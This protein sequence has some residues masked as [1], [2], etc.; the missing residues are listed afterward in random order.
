MQGPCKGCGSRTAI[1]LTEYGSLVCTACGVENLSYIN[2]MSSAYSPYCVPLHAPVSYTRLKR[3]QKYLQ[4]ASMQQST[5]S[6][7]EATWRYLLAGR[8]YRGPGAIV[9]RLKGAPRTLKK[10]CYDSLPL[11]TKVCCP[12]V[13]VPTLSEHE[14]KRAVLHFRQLDDKYNSGEPFVSYLYALEYILV[15]VGRRDVLHYINMIQ[16]QK[17]RIAYRR[18]LNKIFHPSSSSPRRLA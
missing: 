3:F 11:L 2:T 5:T 1:R 6:V 9:R 14:C 8:P 10:K 18:R 4:R 12:H 16:C 13:T 7:P 15:L 17:R